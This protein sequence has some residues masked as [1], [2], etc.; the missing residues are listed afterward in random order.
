VL[1]VVSMA[2]SSTPVQARP[3]LVEDLVFDVGM[4]LGEDTAY[5]LRKGFRV[6]AFEAHPE[7]VEAAHKR[8]ATEVADGRLTVVSGAIVDDARESVTFYA[9]SRISLWGTVAPSRADRNNL[10]GPSVEITVP[11]VDF[12]RCLHDHGAPHYL[13]IDIEAADMVCLESLLEIEPEHRPHYTSIE[14]ESEAWSD[15]VRQFDLLE[16]LGYSRFAIV[17]Q[18]LIGKRRGEITTRDRRT[19]PH[20]F[21]MHSSGP[22]GEDLTAAWLT[23]ADALRR[24][25]WVLRALRAGA[26]FDRWVPKGAEIRFVTGWV[27]RRPLPGW[28]DIHAAR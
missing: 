5:Y 12:A 18:M 14:A 21:E 4:H 27:T 26:T 23:K 8:F 25:R 19:V 24:Y 7:L 6:V 22:F 28:F 1:E 9:H 15:V 20:R 3:Q 17:Q 13:K 11:T 16:Q 2:P 10:M